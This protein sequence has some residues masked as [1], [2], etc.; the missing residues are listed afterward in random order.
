MLLIMK[1]EYVHKATE[2]TVT[3]VKEVWF[4]FIEVLWFII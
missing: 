4:L 1:N 2:R 3:V